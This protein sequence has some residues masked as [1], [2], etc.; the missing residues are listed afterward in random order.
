MSD[1]REGP[2]EDLDDVEDM[3][4]ADDE[5]LAEA[6]RGLS[7]RTG[8]LSGL[9][10]GALIGAGVALLVAPARGEVPRRR[11]GR[12]VRKLADD[13]R[14][15]VEDWTDDAKRELHRQRRRLR[16]RMRR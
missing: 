15:K 11:L 5:D 7:G 2:D 12:R 3:D 4:E 16:K 10:L 9:V 6:P 14:G 13:T 8:F 1:E